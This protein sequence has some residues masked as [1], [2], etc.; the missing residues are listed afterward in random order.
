MTTNLKTFT[1]ASP[2]ISRDLRAEQDAWAADCA[3]AQT[4]PLFELRDPGVEDCTVFYRASVKTERL[5]GRAYLEMWCRL[6][7]RGEFFSRGLAHALAGTNDWVSCETPFRLEKGQR[8]D[9]IRLNLVVAA[10]G[11]IFKKAVAGKVWIRHVALERSA[12]PA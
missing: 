10:A 2:T 12:G 6:P 5:S 1:T 3:G 8:P 9:L 11:R 7:G 4:F